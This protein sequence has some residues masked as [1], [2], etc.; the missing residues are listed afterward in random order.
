MGW[1]RAQDLSGHWLGTAETH[2]GKARVVLN[3]FREEG[4]EAASIA[5]PEFFGLGKTARFDS[6][7]ITPPSLFLSW[8]N[9]FWIR[10]RMVNDTTITGTYNST[11]P[12]VTAKIH[13]RRVQKIPDLKRPQTPEPPFP[14]KNHELSYYDT[15]TRESYQGVLTVPAA[16]PASPEKNFPAILLL[17]G[18]GKHDKN[19]SEGAHELFTVMADY[20]TRNGYAVF[21]K[22]SRGLR[23]PALNP[24]NLKLPDLVQEAEAALRFV[25]QQPQID[26]NQIGLIGHSEGGLVAPQIALKD[27]SVKFLILLATP[28]VAWKKILYYQIL[29]Q[30][31]EKWKDKP[32]PEIFKDTNIVFKTLNPATLSPR[33][34]FLLNYDPA[35]TL[36]K[37]R[38]PVLALTGE[39]DLQINATENI[40][41]MTRALQKTGNKNSSALVLP[42]INHSLQKCVTCSYSE[43][44]FLEETI[45]PEILKMMTDWFNK[46]KGD[47]NQ[48]EFPPTNEK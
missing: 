28:A 48:T 47:A 41:A 25:K 14:Y 34:S 7:I 44:I 10:A 16:D 39:K 19:Y 40:D 9:R 43:N 20:L 46:L 36:S 13:L 32:V 23:N 26:S 2:A 27:S 4:E 38:I 6:V 29:S 21:R 3:F 24:E 18:S 31:Q 15:A 37:L 42:G 11:Q 17:P 30:Q 8:R 1:A 45:A 12:D 33:M 5:I 22:D 35:L